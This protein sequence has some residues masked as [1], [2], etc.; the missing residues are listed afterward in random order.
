MNE[1][2]VFKERQRTAT[3]IYQCNIELNKYQLRSRHVSRLRS[4]FY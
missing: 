3:L 4:N 2:A 1:A